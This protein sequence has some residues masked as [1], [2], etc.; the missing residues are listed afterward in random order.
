LSGQ[1]LSI[2]GSTWLDKALLQLVN[3]QSTILLS[4][5]ID[6]DRERLRQRYAYLAF[7]FTAGKALIVSW[8]DD[9]NEC[10]WHGVACNGAMISSIN[11]NNQGLAGSIPADV[12]LWNSITIFRA[13]MNRLGGSLPSSIGN[14]A[15]LTIFNVATNAL[16][17]SLP[18]SIGK[19]TSLTYF[20]ARNNQL[21]GT[22]PSFIGKWT[23]LKAF[24]VLSNR[25]G[26]SLPTSIG[27][28]TGL[29][30]IYLRDNQFTGTV[31][32]SVSN[33]TAIETAYFNSNSFNGIMP[34]VGKTFCPKNTSVGVFYS[35]CSPYANSPPAIIC[36][37]CSRCCA[38]DFCFANNL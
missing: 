19:W 29:T 18:S 27:A 25:L 10:Q 3:A 16:G 1:T 9:A 15:D 12:G 24:S 7:V 8:F 13:Y 28:W 23:G 14:W 22:L 6:E 38:F 20:V 5:C 4:T 2:S 17:G 32:M 21:S 31:P 26:G 35:D 11:L 37:C 36:K 34:P 30:E 33:W